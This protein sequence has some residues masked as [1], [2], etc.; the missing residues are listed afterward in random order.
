MQQIVIQNQT[1]RADSLVR[2][3]LGFV[4]ISSLAALSLL[5]LLAYQLPATG[6]AADYE[7]TQSTVK[8]ESLPAENPAL[9]S[10][11]TIEETTVETED[12]GVFNDEKLYFGE[13]VYAAQAGDNLTYF[14]RRSVQLY[15]AEEPQINLETSQVIAA[16]THIVQDLGAFELAIGQEV[17]IDVALVA[18]HVETARSLDK[19]AKACWAAYEPVRENL[20][21][22]SPV[23]LPQSTS[24]STQTDDQT[25]SPTADNGSDSDSGNSNSTDDVVDG[26]GG[27]NAI[28][29][30]DSS[31]YLILFSALALAT[32]GGWILIVIHRQDSRKDANLSWNL[33]KKSAGKNKLADSAIAQKAKALPKTL[34]KQKEKL[35]KRGRPVG[36]GDKKKRKR[37]FK[38]EK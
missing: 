19:T 32:I 28:A 9:G 15:V 37:R 3:A 31:F 16:E 29:E 4:L 8:E 10:N 18:S 6:W 14:A 26:V 35:K 25:V 22:L 38:K 23:R 20:S 11:E 30:S 7:L 13:Y 36:S 5:V 17:G 21:S 1:L 34:A 24:L 12:S 33:E 2:S 27:E